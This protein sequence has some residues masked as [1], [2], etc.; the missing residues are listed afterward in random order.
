[1]AYELEGT[2]L[3]VCTCNIL[4]PCW[5]GE[6]PDGDGYCDAVMA[7]HIDRGTIN[8]TD[9]SDRT[10]SLINHIPGNV[11]AGN[12]KVALFVDDK[13]SEAQEKAMLDVWTGKAGGPVADLV[14]LVGEVVAIERATISYELKEGKGT[15]RIGNI[16]DAAMEPY[17]GPTGAVTTLNESI[18]TT[19]PGAPAWV[20][21]AS[22]YKRSSKQYGLMNIDLQGHN[23]IQGS[24]RFEHN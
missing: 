17:R 16:V 24:F 9:V 6:D 18:F 1:M 3:E 11:L 19:I 4:C 20:A 12:W 15:L 8:G 14:Q 2:I 13:A 23:A 22:H 7:W 5:V 21:K 10:M